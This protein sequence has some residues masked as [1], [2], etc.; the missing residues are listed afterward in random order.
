MF[1]YDIETLGV[2]SDSVILSMGCIYIADPNPKSIDDLREDSFYVKLDAK[3]QIDKLGRT[4]SQ[5][6]LAWWKKQE[7]SVRDAA[8]KPSVEDVKPLEAIHML[9]RFAYSKV[10]NNPSKC[11]TRGFMDVF[12]TEHLARQVETTLPWKYNDFLDVRTAIELLYP[13][14]K[15]GYVDVDP[16][17]CYNFDRAAVKKHHPVWD[18]ALDAAMI[19]FGKVD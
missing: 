8:C 3:Y 10:G 18:C 12:V 19:L 7:K 9:R 11:Y 2:D 17:K 4:V 14:S 6:T 16:T 13:N 1:V 15:N 5:D